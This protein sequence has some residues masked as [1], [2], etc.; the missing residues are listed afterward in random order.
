MIR[1]F[2]DS[3]GIGIGRENVWEIVKIGV[4]T[5]EVVLDKG[6]VLG[7]MNEQNYHRFT[8]SPCIHS[9]F[10]L[11][12]PTYI[13]DEAIIFSLMP[14]IPL[15]QLSA[16]MVQL[17]H[18]NLSPPKHLLQHRCLVS[19]KHIHHT[20]QLLNRRQRSIIPLISLR[21]IENYQAPST[22]IQDS[23]NHL[24]EDHL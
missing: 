5:L 21:L 4:L 15:P 1:I 20:T 13:S 22:L 16:S 19:I 10:I 12:Y 23:D 7:F 6:L 24:I 11:G 2:V 17:C 8:L 3:I 18:P 14:F 9:V